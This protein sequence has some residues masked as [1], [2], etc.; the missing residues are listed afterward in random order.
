MKHLFPFCFLLTLIG[1][2]SH[3]PKPQ[4][5][6]K[7]VSQKVVSEQVISGKNKSYLDNPLKAKVNQRG[8][9]R[10]VRSGGLIDNP[11]TSTGKAVSNPVIQLVKSTQR[12]PLI[13]GAQMY[14]QYRFWYLPN[15]PAYVNFRRVLKHPEMTLPDGSV[16][17][18]S[19]YIMK[20][21]VS[22]N[23]VIAYTGYGLDEDYELVEGDWT[24]EIWYQD[25]KMI[26]QK[27][28]TY[29]PDK[30]EIAALKPVLMLGNKVFTQAPQSPKLSKK[31]SFSKRNWPRVIVGGE[32]TEPDQTA[33][34]K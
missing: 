2:N 34:K 11:A 10:L 22:V 5:S 14:L 30:A 28:T 23:Q 18:G 29:W 15:R 17:T 27:F 31:T 20:G 4:D 25:K 3:A 9:Y 13:K 32:S 7:V 24:F 21:K 1:C 8:L 12:I 33:S 6:A 26:E 19:D 16:A